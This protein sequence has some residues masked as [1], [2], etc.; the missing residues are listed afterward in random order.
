MDLL[1]QCGDR[2]KIWID[3]SYRRRN[4]PKKW[5]YCEIRGKAGAIWPYSETHLVVAFYHGWRSRIDVEGDVIWIPAKRSQQARRFRVLAGSDAE[6]VQDC[7]EVTCFK[8]PNKY[9][10]RAL[11]SIDARLKRRISKAVQE[12]L[13]QAS[14]S[15]ALIIGGEGLSGPFLN[16][17]LAVGPSV[18]QP[19]SNVEITHG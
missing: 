14:K 4:F 12:R 16:D 5:R 11:K 1:T 6:V 8:V 13:S 10:H 15:R 9:L 19:A 18:P 17:L 7:D 3:R 2:Y